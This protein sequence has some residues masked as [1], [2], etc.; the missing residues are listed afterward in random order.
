[1]VAAGLAGGAGGAT[2]WSPLRRKTTT[3]SMQ[4]YRGASGKGKALRPELEWLLVTTFCFIC[5][6]PKDS[7]RRRVGYQ[8]GDERSEG[9]FQICVLT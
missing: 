3:L 4:S 1:M 9:G 8:R 6:G 5:I 2:L 7:C